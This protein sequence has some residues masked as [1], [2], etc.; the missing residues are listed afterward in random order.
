MKSVWRM[1]APAVLSTGTWVIAAA[2]GMPLDGLREEADMLAN[3]SAYAQPVPCMRF[4]GGREFGAIAGAGPAD[5]DSGDLAQLVRQETFAMPSFAGAGP[6]ARRCGAVHGPAPAGAAQRAALATLYIVLMCDYCLDALDVRGDVV[7]EGAF[8]GNP[9]FAPLLAALRAA[10]GAR[11]LATD[12]TSG[13]TCG[14]WLLHRREGK[15]QLQGRAA[16]PL[17]LD[18]LQAYRQRWR[19]LIRE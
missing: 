3:S 17:A 19:E 10:P 14:G 7:V 18:G 11:V 1:P 12:D 5:F 9:Y 15:P 2:P 8:T 6:F 13:T 16:G 4:M